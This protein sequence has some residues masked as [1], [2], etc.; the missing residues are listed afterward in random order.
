MCFIGISFK[1]IECDIT[2]NCCK[3]TNTCSTNRIRK[4]FFLLEMLDCQFTSSSDGF[5][6]SHVLWWDKL[7]QSS[8]Y[9]CFQLW[10]KLDSCFEAGNSKK[11]KLMA[12]FFF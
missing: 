5:C 10:T 6:L 12:A 9:Y 4:F 7:P 2:T 3:C 11:V 1:H 8:F